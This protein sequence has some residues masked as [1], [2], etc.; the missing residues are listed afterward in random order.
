MTGGT[1]NMTATADATTSGGRQHRANG[2]PAKHAPPAPRQSPAPLRRGLVARGRL[3]ERLAATTDKPV[4]ALIAPAGYGKSTLLSEWATHD[5]RP[6]AWVTLQNADNDP[7]RLVET[8]STALDGATG[9]RPEILG[10][11]PGLPSRSPLA[12]ER[13]LRRRLENEETSFV[14]VVD[15]VH[16]LHRTEAL[17]LLTTIASHLRVGSQLAIGARSDPDLPL[18]HMRAQRVLAELRMPDLAMTEDEAGRMLAAAGLDLD[19][20][21]VT[22]LIERTEG[23]PAGLQLAALSIH[24]QPDM[25]RAVARFAGDDRLVT[26]YLHDALLSSL[27]AERLN[28]LL[29]TSVLDELSGSLCDAVLD[30]TGSAEVLRK[31]ARSNLLLIALDRSDERYRYHPSCSVAC[32]A[33]FSAVS[34][35]AS[36]GSTFAQA[37]FMQNIAIRT[38]PSSMRC[39]PRSSNAPAS[40]SGPTFPSATP[41]ACSAGWSGFP[42]RTS[43]HMRRWR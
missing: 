7:A 25:G 17:A 5:E 42:S 20:A 6:F 40:S 43:R 2:A 8:I 18:G 27:P 11:R 4:A 30:R 37:P 35:S 14:L 1:P 36:V 38:G 13:R 32:A 10:V 33:S 26:D 34:R 12:A 28:F 16:R 19:S 15:E 23:W 31:M 24:E 41:R 29:R 22:T 21:Q 39:P 3:L 9:V